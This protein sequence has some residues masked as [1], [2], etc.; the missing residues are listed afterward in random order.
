MFCFALLFTLYYIGTRLVGVILNVDMRV[1]FGTAPL[2]LIASEHIVVTCL[3][4]F[5]FASDLEWLPLGS[6]FLCSPSSEYS[7]PNCIGHHGIESQVTGSAATNFHLM[8]V[9][10]EY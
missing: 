9:V 5:R 3:S 10:P 6:M 4:T 2:A 8:I 7:Q 1:V